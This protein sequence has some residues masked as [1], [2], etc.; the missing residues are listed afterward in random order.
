MSRLA[1]VLPLVLAA[2][3]RGGHIPTFVQSASIQGYDLVITECTMATDHEKV[4]ASNCAE[5]REH[6][7]V[8]VAR[9]AIT[10]PEA[11]A[12]LTAEDVAD[13]IAPVRAALEACA[14]DHEIPGV[15]RLAITI[16]PKGNTTSVVPD[17]V[18]PA[19]A[20]CVVAAFADA[21]FLK[22]RRGAKLTFSIGA[23]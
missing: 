21:R 13:G 2:C 6:L 17:V 10:E 5:R 22:T 11:P 14:R 18:H 9:A 3:T 1:F 23:P 20:A 4:V 7:P 8:L 16:A 19:Y 15:V 12:P